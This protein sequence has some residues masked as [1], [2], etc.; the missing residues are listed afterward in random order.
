M[1]QVH[2]VTFGIRA[3]VLSPT[4]ACMTELHH[5]EGMISPVQDPLSVIKKTF[6]SCCACW[7]QVF[8]AVVAAGLG[9]DWG[10][11]GHSHVAL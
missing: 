8:G 5:A 11:S 6:Q 9:L 7:Q 4:Y 2:Q 1:A 3:A 10:C